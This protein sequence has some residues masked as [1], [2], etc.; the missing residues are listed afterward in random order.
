MSNNWD[1]LVVSE[2]VSCQPVR[3]SMHH[4]YTRK[5]KKDSQ[6]TA[7]PNFEKQVVEEIKGMEEP[8]NEL[9]TMVDLLTQL[10][11]KIDGLSKPQ[12]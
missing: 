7:D 8:P 11:K 5:S 6:R 10:V 2:L 1:I 3:E 9:K 4:Y 12:T